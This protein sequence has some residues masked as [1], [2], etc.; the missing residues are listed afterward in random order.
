MCM[1]AGTGV[2]DG[3][4]GRI[5]IIVAPNYKGVVVGKGAAVQRVGGRDD[6][7]AHGEDS[8]GVD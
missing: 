8:V 3:G 5:L 7:N 4:D 6:T 1:G 2:E